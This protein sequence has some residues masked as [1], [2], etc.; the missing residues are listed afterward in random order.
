MARLAT[1]AASEH[2]TE[3]FRSFMEGMGDATAKASDVAEK[4][5]E[6]LKR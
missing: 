4:L 2:Y 5:G 3:R 1:D 6:W